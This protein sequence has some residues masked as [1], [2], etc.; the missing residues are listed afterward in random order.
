V[1]DAA[2]IATCPPADATGVTFSLPDPEQR[3][4]GV[5]LVQEVA[6]PR[7][8]P[9]FRRSADGT[10]WAVRLERPPVDRMEYQL[11]LLHPDGRTE[12]ICDPANPLR[13]PGP[14]GDKSVVEFP[15]YHPPAW[16]TAERASPPGD[17][18]DLTFH[19]P[20]LDGSMHVRLWSSPGTSADDRLPLLLAH[21]GIDYANYSGLTVMLDRLTGDGTLPP[22]RAALLHPVHRDEHYAASPTYARVL[23]E[24]LLPFLHAQGPIA[25]GRHMRVGLGA[26]LGGLALLH[27]H[28][29]YPSTLG[30]LFLQSASLFHHRY[31]RFAISLEHFTRIRQFLDRVHAERDWHSPIPIRMTCGRV[32]MNFA[33]NRAASLALRRQGYD[34]DFRPVQDAHN[35]IGWRDA[36]SPGLVR[37][38]QALWT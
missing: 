34:L 38:L 2:P 32:E 28:R 18:A 19:S 20:D 1:L 22:M 23:S 30:G 16:L 35:W 36:W 27:A 8:G 12:L 4:A 21:D 7:A 24:Q 31:D 5:W 29:T 15:G 3:L 11:E 26:S 13:A 10:S 6:V 17:A 9:E 33:N 14:F 37:L 25:P